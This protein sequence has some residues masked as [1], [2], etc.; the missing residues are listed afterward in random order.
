MDVLNGGD[1]N[2]RVTFSAQSQKGWSVEVPETVEI[3]GGEEETIEFKVYVPLRAQIN[4]I[5]EILFK[6]ESRNAEK[7]YSITGTVT[8]TAAATYGMEP[9]GDTV[10]ALM[11]G[12]TYMFQV[13]V[14]NLQNLTKNFEMSTEDLPGSWAVTYSSDGGELQGNLYI[15]EINASG[16]EVVNIVIATSSGGPYGSTQV[17]TYVRARGESEKKYTYFTLK[18]V[19]DS[20]SVVD[21]PSEETRETASRVGS[22][23][24][25]A[26]T[27]VYFTFEL[28]N[29]TLDDLE[30]E[31]NVDEPDGWN[32]AA[33][34]DD[35][36]LSPGSGSLWNLSITPK[37]GESWNLGNAYRIDVT[38]DA[39][40]EGEF[41]KTLEVILPE[42]SDIRS[43]KEWSS[44][45]TK[46]GNTIPLNI[47]FTNKGNK[48]E[49]VTLS[50][51]NPPELTVNLTPISKSI[52]PGEEFTARGEIKVGSI[53]EVGSYSL[54]LRYSTSKGDTS[55]DYS[56]YVEK[57][58]SSSTIDIVPF[59]IGAIVL[60]VLGVAGFV[61]FNRYRSGKGK[62][63]E[64]P[65]KPKKESKV[66]VSSSPD[67]PKKA[68][69]LRPT[70]PEEI[71]VIKEAD[72]A[73]ASILGEDAVKKE[74]EKF[75]VVEA[76]VVE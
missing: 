5:D 28:Y 20:I 43:Q 62:D 71:K 38:V 70:S 10:K 15:F 26:Y 55:I 58:D 29:P 61:L 64:K 4:D 3:E 53:E 74:P 34:Y 33:D 30:I 31:M 24:P 40:S 16:E 13:R 2:D 32:Y 22:T 67:T 42:V 14:I 66:T 41:S 54:K 47:T 8:V 39:G 57:S 73:L 18:V 72:E 19:D 17:G 44:I 35:I 50:I 59:L 52:A 37:T 68:P 21:I 7:T 49:T 60:I 6:A 45:N 48:D 76:T 75:E 51:E 46:E 36:L 65:A 25:V 63:G 11:A 12:S 27:K 23:Y 9:V 69:P 56:L 1:A